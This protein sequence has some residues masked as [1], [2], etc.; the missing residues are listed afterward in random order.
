[1]RKSLLA[2]ICAA[3]LALLC[4]CGAQTDA[5]PTPAPNSADGILTS[6]QQTI[7]LRLASAFRMFGTYDV[8]IGTTNLMEQ[9]FFIFCYYT[10]HLAEC[11]V[12][13]FGRVPISDADRLLND[14][15]GPYEITDLLRTKFDPSKEQTYYTLDDNYYVLITDGSAYDFEIKSAETTERGV[16]VIVT[17]Y[18][19][20]AGECDITLV[21]DSNEDTSWGY[22][23][24]SATIKMWY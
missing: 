7:V 6:D 3:L 9:E 19:D 4:A 23:V 8:D 22:V 14:T 5:D 17:V 21:L 20:G 2:L 18:K 15:F 11:E 24:R 13:G 10:D 16:S 12:D 1:M